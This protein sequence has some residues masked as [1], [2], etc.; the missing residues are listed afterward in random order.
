MFLPSTRFYRGD[1]HTIGPNSIYSNQQDDLFAGV[2]VAFTSSS[3]DAT[4]FFVD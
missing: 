3:D 1:S 2:D 4:L